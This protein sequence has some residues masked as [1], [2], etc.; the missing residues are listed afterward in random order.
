MPFSA[1]MIC[2]SPPLPSFPFSGNGI[3][4]IVFHSPSPLLARLATTTRRR[5]RRE[6]IYFNVPL[7]RNCVRHC[8][9]PFRLCTLV[10]S[11][12]EA[13]CSVCQ[14]MKNIAR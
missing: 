6:A 1:R 13:M 8:C 11:P 3:W 7:S 4:D 14:I 12:A 5:R 9:F 10:I 2:C